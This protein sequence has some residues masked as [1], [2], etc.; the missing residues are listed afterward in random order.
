MGFDSKDLKLCRCITEQVIILHN[1][2]TNIDNAA[3]VVLSLLTVL[4]ISVK[5]LVGS[6]R[7]WELTKLRHKAPLCKELL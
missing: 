2:Y 1:K 4:E 6:D 7:H 3:S 5:G